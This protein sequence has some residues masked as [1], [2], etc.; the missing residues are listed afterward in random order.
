MFL[1]INCMH[2]TLIQCKKILRQLP[3]CLQSLN[4]IFD[5]TINL[6]VHENVII[7]ITYLTKKQ[8]TKVTVVIPGKRLYHVYNHP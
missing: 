8:A 7:L 1:N 3:L 6:S 4:G 2:T 5:F